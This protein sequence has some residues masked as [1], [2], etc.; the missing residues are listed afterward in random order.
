MNEFKDSWS[1]VLRRL[2]ITKVEWINAFMIFF[3]HFEIKVLI[4]S[5]ICMT[6][7]LGI[8]WLNI[9]IWISH[10]WIWFKSYIRTYNDFCIW[11]T[12]IAIDSSHFLLI[13]RKCSQSIQLLRLHLWDALLEIDSSKINRSNTK[14]TSLRAALING[15][16]NSPLHNAWLL[17]LPSAFPLKNYQ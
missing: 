9:L 15:L 5:F 11:Y 12:L 4:S 8:Q 16:C 1:K 7:F 13:I 3:I 10:F 14:L 6:L 2:T 17:G